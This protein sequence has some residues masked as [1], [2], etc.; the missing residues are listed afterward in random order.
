ME[1]KVFSVIKI[2]GE[3]FR[4]TPDN[5]ILEIKPGDSLNEGDIIIVKS[6]TV[7]V[8][9]ASGSPLEF[10]E[11]TSFLIKNGGN[12]TEINKET[13]DFSP[14]EPQNAEI[15]NQNTTSRHGENKPKSDDSDIIKPDNGERSGDGHGF[16]RLERTDY[17][18]DNVETGFGRDANEVYSF[19]GRATLNPRVNYK[20]IYPEP[21][22]EI[23]GSDFEDLKYIG[24][25]KSGWANRAPMAR[26]DSAVTEEDM[27]LII[28]PLEND[29]DPDGHSLSITTASALYGTVTINA[30]GTITYIP[31]EDF[32]GDDT[33]TYTITDNYGGTAESTVS[34][35][36]NPVQDAFND[37]VTTDEDSSVTINVLANDTFGPNAE[38]TSVTQGT[39]G[40]VVINENGEIT[41][42]PG[43]YY[44]SLAEGTS[45][46]DTYTYTVTTAAGNTETAAVTV[47]I[48]GTNDVPVVTNL[49]AETA[50]AVTE[51][52]HLDDGTVVTGT[53]TATGNL[54]ASD[55]DTGATQTWSLTGSQPST[56]G[57]MSVDS[58][59]GIWTYTLDNTLAA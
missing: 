56:Y 58:S 41:Y 42:I 21:K 34:V 48:L 22:E 4:Q 40:S 38:V 6:G 28:N 50:G 59:T 12:Y 15:Q 24:P 9:S 45:A 54:D 13:M 25:A 16:V 37:I 11:G 36:V 51:A 35:T 14:K 31:N 19:N 8:E 46:T 2:N 53:A 3:A 32:H 23:S 49:P 29:T 18:A 52:G 43:E 44:Q 26:P 5:I 47:T 57:T 55:V 10:N 33:I 17:N 7:E 27:P 30:D 39:H 1:N 20:Y